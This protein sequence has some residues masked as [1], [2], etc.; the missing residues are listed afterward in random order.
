MISALTAASRGVQY[1]GVRAIL[2]APLIKEYILEPS[3]VACVEFGICVIEKGHDL[4]ERIKWWHDQTP[5][6]KF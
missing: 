2:L 5:G 1:L 4:I 6:S 3:P